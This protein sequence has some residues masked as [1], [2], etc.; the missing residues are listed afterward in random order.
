VYV[1]G[2]KTR[3]KEATRKAKIRWVDGF[4]M[5]LGEIG[6]GVVDRIDPA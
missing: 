1:I 4:K 3:R 5:D 6:W 2:G